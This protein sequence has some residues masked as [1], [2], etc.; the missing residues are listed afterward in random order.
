[1]TDIEA[2]AIATAAGMVEDQSEGEAMPVSHFVS[3]VLHTDRV[4]MIGR[5][6]SGSEKAG[7]GAQP[8]L[9]GRVPSATMLASSQRPSSDSPNGLGLSVGQCGEPF[10]VPLD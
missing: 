2:A 3:A 9:G 6:S 4:S 5:R 7:C 8:H 10:G 1:M